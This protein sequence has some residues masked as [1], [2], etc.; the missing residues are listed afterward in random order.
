MKSERFEFSVSCNVEKE[1][2][3]TGMD[4]RKLS[5]SNS[6]T[7]N[8]HEG[9]FNYPYKHGSKYLLLCGL[10]FNMYKITAAKSVLHVAW[11]IR[12]NGNKC[13]LFRK[14]RTPSP[15]NILTIQKLNNRQ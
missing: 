12:K 6:R 2:Y 1:F 4:I 10:I 3:N 13:V 5:Q 11:E 9:I 15:L 7:Y 14:N 8:P